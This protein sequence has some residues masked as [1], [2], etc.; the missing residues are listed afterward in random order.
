MLADNGTYTAMMAITTIYAL[1]GDDLRLGAMPVWLDD[2]FFGISLV[3]MILFA[4]EI[5][6]MSLAKP[7]TYKFKFYFWLDLV[8]TLS[9]LPD[10]GWIWD[11][12]VGEDVQKSDTSALRTGRTSRAGARAGRIV[13][14]VRLVRLV[15]LAKFV[16]NVKGDDTD[17]TKQQLKD[18]PS[19][20]GRV[21]TDKS[22]IK[23]ISV[24]LAM[25]FVVPWLDGS[26]TGIESHFQE[27]GL[28]SLHR[29]SFSG[30]NAD[31]LELEVL[32]YVTAGDMI[33]FSLTKGTT[34]VYP[35]VS[36][37]WVEEDGT[38]LYSETYIDDNYRSA[39]V[40]LLQTVG[41]Y[42]SN[43]TEID[44]SLMALDDCYSFAYFSMKDDI[45]WDAWM[46]MLKTFFIMFLLVVAS[47]AF[48]RDAEKLVIQPIE[49]MVKTIK[50][51]A[52][53]PLA[54]VVTAPTSEQSSYETAVLEKTLGKIGALLQVGFG[55]AG[56][57][58]IARNMASGDELDPMVKGKKMYAVFGFCD[59]RRFTDA[60][61]CLQE[62]VMVFVNEI[63]AIVHRAVHEFG[64]AANKNI[65]DAFLLV[66]K[67]PCALEGDLSPEDH[68]AVSR[69]VDNALAAFLK[70]QVD[71]EESNKR[72]LLAKYATDPRIAPRFEEGYSVKMGFGLHVGWA[73]EGAIGSSYKI[74][75]SYLSPHVNMASRL[76]AATKQFRTPLLL[77]ADFHSMLSPPAQHICRC[78][79]VVTVKGS[80]APMGLFAC[81]ISDMEIGMDFGDLRGTHRFIDFATSACVGAIQASLPGGF[82]AKWD[83]AIKAYIAGNFAKAKAAAEAAA[84]MRGGDGPA[85]TL[86]SVMDPPP[87][88]PWKGFRALTEK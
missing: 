66:W 46:S 39:E 81:D 84:K 25:L 13:R 29:L 71:I 76:E 55:E 79:D 68:A 74:D 14:I 53:N 57:E 8:A 77:S 3:A 9:M 58:I 59:I 41:C 5:T 78:I 82:M 38:T 1:F 40:N 67:L 45:V 47:F 75:A 2:L 6:V 85:V 64:G 36:Q 27:A 19:Q 43:G 35:N 65:G 11:P 88:G 54:T 44:S 42:Y 83:E 15:R 86:L 34:G 22:T 17:V 62:D 73:I 33:G 23:L 72:G 10:I 87:A 21:L 28:T 26:A 20:V 16:K 32:S 52:R 12:L 50:S 37:A 80:E 51:L 61:E 18:K 7:D 4:I 31:T 63:G 60:T 70:I 24:V 49:R 69:V 48:T 30:V 56:A